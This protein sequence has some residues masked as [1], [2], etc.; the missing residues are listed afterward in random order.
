MDLLTSKKLLKVIRCYLNEV[1]CFWLQCK[2]TESSPNQENGPGR[3]R[4]NSVDGTGT[5]S[6][7]IPSKHDGCN[8]KNLIIEC[9]SEAIPEDG[10]KSPDGDHDTPT[11]CKHC[12]CQGGFKAWNSSS[13]K[14][15]PNYLWRKF[16]RQKEIQSQSAS[17]LF[18]VQISTTAQVFHVRPLLRSSRSFSFIKM[19]LIPVEVFGFRY[20]SCSCISIP[21]VKRF[22]RE[23]LVVCLAVYF[24][25]H[26]HKTNKYTEISIKFIYLL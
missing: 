6:V 15:K 2:L 7:T 19:Q 18:I 1:N 25:Q 4:S 16:T 14:E 3:V 23:S 22:K 5:R 12:G 17:S 21:L 9:G 10:E 20:E 24:S 26:I 8:P 11:V 13:I